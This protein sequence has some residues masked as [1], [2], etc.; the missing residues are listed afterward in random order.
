[1]F[2]FQRMSQMF[3][4]SNASFCCR[5]LHLPSFIYQPS[6]VLPIG[7]SFNLHWASGGS[8]LRTSK[9]AE[10]L[11]TNRL[12]PVQS[13]LGR[14]GQRFVAY[15]QHFSQELLER[16]QNGSLSSHQMKKLREQE[17]RCSKS[18]LRTEELQ[19]DCDGLISLVLEA[20][21]DTSGDRQQQQK[22]RSEMEAE[23]QRIEQEKSDIEFSSF[24]RLGELEESDTIVEIHPGAGGDD[25]EN[26]AQMLLHMYEK[27]CAN[28]G[29]S[30]E[31]LDL[32]NTSVG[33][34]N[35]C[36]KVEGQ[37]SYCW[38]RTESGVHRLVRTSPFSSNGMRHT[39]FASVKVYPTA[40][41]S[42][43][44]ESSNAETISI[45]PD[46]LEIKTMRASGPGGQHMQKTES[47]VRILHKPTGITASCSSTRSQ[48]QN[49]KLAMEVVQSR[50]LML[51]LEQQAREK[52]ARRLQSLDS[53]GAQIRNYVLNPYQ[54]VVD[55]RTKYSGNP[56]R[57][58]EDGE[59]DD[60][61]LEA[62]RA[63]TDQFLAL[64]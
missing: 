11:V 48:H 45:N 15:Q 14:V 39:S 26:W 21:Q 1:M 43:D 17:K 64:P 53:W 57:L 44:G 35:V 9:W 24:Q 62:L 7:C 23:I 5:H 6:A 13:I 16:G 4:F 46:D 54:T 8:P 47:A 55:S 63:D 2:L 41:S 60:F 19:G 36:F 28:H 10:T 42:P 33:I 27:W 18:T 61:I 56:A 31:L 22:F 3:R 12:K 25:S 37:F 34:R 40:S 49:R 50:L 59:F 32:H 51:Q 30:F 38:L 52:S 29:F 58:L 20:E